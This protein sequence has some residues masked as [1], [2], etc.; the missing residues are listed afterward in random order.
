MGAAKTATRKAKLTRAE[1]VEANRD[2][3]IQAAV[4]VIGEE[5]YF[6]ASI[7]KITQRAGLGLGTF[8]RHFETQQELFDLLLPVKGAELLDHL[9][10]AATGATDFVEVELRGMEAFFRWARKNPWF[11]RL[12]HEAH[13]AAPVAYKRHIENIAERYRRSLL[14]SWEKGE[15]P[16]F[17]KAELETLT[18][19]LISMRDYVFAEYVERSEDSDDSISDVIETYRKLITFGL[20]RGPA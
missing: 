4:E 16:A 9:Q 14:R 2:A 5:G 3:L 7:Q 6:N 10:K 1:K 20:K 13:V 12:L 15:L 11:F 8:Y 17:E 19:L 18:Y